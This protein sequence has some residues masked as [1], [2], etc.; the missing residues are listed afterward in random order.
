MNQPKFTLDEYYATCNSTERCMEL[1]FRELDQ[2]RLHPL[3]TKPITTDKSDTNISTKD[4][5]KNKIPN[6]S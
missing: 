3:S 2:K 4:N 6:T 1:V 5:P